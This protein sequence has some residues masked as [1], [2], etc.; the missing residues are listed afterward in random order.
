MDFLWS[1]ESGLFFGGLAQCEDEGDGAYCDVHV[2]DSS[3]Y[4]ASSC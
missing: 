2:L 4:F 1:V 3:R